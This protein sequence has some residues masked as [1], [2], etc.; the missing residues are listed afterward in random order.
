MNLSTDLH[1]SI[2]ENKGTGYGKGETKAASEF[3]DKG[4]EKGDKKAFNRAQ[5]RGKSKHIDASMKGE[6]L[7]DELE[8]SL[9]DE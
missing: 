1:E 5:R 6:S 8:R 4:P 9:S 2:E 7:A 3:H